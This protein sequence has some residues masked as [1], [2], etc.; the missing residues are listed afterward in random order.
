VIVLKGL[1]LPPGGVAVFSDVPTGAW[2]APY[3]AAAHRYGIVSGVTETTFDPFGGIT[4]EAAA[5]MLFRAARLCGADAALEPARV[6]T[7]LAPFSDAEKISV[8]ARE[9]VA[10]G[11][12]SGILDAGADDIA[13]H[14]VMRR[15][16][17]ARMVYRLLARTG[18]LI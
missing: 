12:E 8:W 3:V 10:F 17:I 16:D 1:G 9:A 13:P 11:C 5:V 6:S 18:L 14:S 4:K 7:V 2:Y 15:A